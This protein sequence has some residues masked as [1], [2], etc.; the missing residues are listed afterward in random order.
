MRGHLIAEYLDQSYLRVPPIRLVQEYRRAIPALTIFEDLTSEDYQ[1][2]QLLRQAALLLPQDKMRLLQELLARSQNLDEAVDEFRK[3]RADSI[4][5]PPENRL[6]KLSENLNNG[7][8]LIVSDEDK[9]L[10]L[11][12]AGWELVRELS[13]DRFLMKRS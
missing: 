7:P 4:S 3:L 5:V 13:G 12:D 6:R 2:R 11:L 1:K 8:H 10:R 9:M